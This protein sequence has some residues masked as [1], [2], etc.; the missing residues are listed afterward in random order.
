MN[1]QLK[2]IIE[3]SAIVGWFVTFIACATI[4]GIE[5]MK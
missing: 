4:I 5:I 2:Q 1:E 3:C